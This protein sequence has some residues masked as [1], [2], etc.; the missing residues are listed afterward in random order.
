MDKLVIT[1]SELE[2]LAKMSNQSYLLES[3]VDLLRSSGEIEITVI[4]D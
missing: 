4:E 2:D 1:E 3:I